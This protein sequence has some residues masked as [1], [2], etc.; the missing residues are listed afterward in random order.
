V[1]L[2]DRMIP[3]ELNLHQK[4]YTFGLSNPNLTAL[5]SNMVDEKQVNENLAVVRG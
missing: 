2:L 4:A 3:G 5:V 1:A